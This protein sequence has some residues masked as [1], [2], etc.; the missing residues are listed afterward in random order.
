[1][2]KYWALL[3]NTIQE[4]SI[5]IQLKGRRN[6][7]NITRENIQH[8]NMTAKGVEYESF[9]KTKKIFIWKGKWKNA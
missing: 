8:K 4:L 9:R 5:Q 6:N 2:L 1:M 3:V 7:E